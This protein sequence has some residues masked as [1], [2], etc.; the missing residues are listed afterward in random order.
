MAIT[1]YIKG[2][3][4]QFKWGALS[5]YSGPAGTSTEKRSAY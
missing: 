3:R 5:I 4:V 2:F 1:T